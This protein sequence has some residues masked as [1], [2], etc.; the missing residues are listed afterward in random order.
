MIYLNKRL[1]LTCLFT[2]VCALS[3][4]AKT[5][6]FSK[7]GQ[8][9]VPSNQSQDQVIAYL[10][11]KLTREA[12]EEAGIFM[13]S[14]MRM[15]EGTITKEE[16]TN[17]A[18]SISKIKQEK[19]KTYTEN[20]QQY[21]YMK[22]KVS[23]DTDSV[24]AFLTKIKQDNTYK[25]EA[26]QLRKKNLQLEQKLRTATKQQF[27]SQLSIEAKHQV[28]IQKQR[29]I[30]YNKMALQAQEELAH[31]AKAQQEQE[32]LRQ[33]QLAQLQR[34]LEA[35]EL[36]RKQQIAKEKD[37][38][39]Q[40]ELENQAQ[41][42]KLEQQAKINSL[43]LLPVSQIS[44]QQAFKETNA[45]RQ[46]ISDIVAEFEEL[47]KT[48]NTKLSQKYAQQKETLLKAKFEQQKPIKD[49]WET[50]QEYN[51]RLQQYQQKRAEFS[52]TQQAYLSQLEANEASAIT[53]NNNE[54][55]T[56]VQNAVIPFVAKL[57]QLQQG[58]YSHADSPRAQLL[59]I[60]NINTDEGYF[61]MN[62][63]Y[64]KKTY[65]L[66]FYFNEIPL[67]QAK[68]LHQTQ[69]QFVIEPLFQ[70]DN[71]KGEAVQVV[72]AFRVL[73][74]G[75]KLQ[76]TL[77]LYLWIEYFPE[78]QEDLPAPSIQENLPD[79]SVSSL[80]KKVERQRTILAAP[81]DGLW[82]NYK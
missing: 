25:E 2:A 18:G 77:Y 67:S 70:I 37:A 76:R 65:P 5:V 41:I 13:K 47:R 29:A 78:I 71:N 73:H 36:A 24:N 48:A 68:L 50:T 31:I 54:T 15:E 20:G 23:V 22:L 52:S 4:S 51:L 28:E 26:E 55:A 56:A 69:Q 57:K 16:I 64:E 3:A 63:R 32:A 9:V 7:E 10:T 80:W 58:I 33:K 17:I 38:I 42:K 21:V 43:Q 72:S 59:S 82:W 19:V 35:E 1:L 27:D 79:S 40:A 39:K 14:E 45:I 49:Q 74:S 8:Q 66:V 44:I 61:V 81:K 75:T 53:A 30:E 60:D 46:K 12:T 62:I 11:Q 34:Q 6:S